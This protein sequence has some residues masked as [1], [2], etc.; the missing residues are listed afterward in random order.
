MSFQTRAMAQAPDLSASMAS[1]D[2]M[3]RALRANT[4]AIRAEW[5]EDELRTD[6]FGF[7]V[8]VDDQST[9]VATA[10]HVIRG[11]S[12]DT[13]AD[14][15]SVRFYGQRGARSAEIVAHYD[16]ALDVGV[17]KIQGRPPKPW[18]RPVSGPET[19]ARRGTQVWFV[20][21]S[22]T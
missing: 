4:V 19:A 9:Y 12:G 16:P 1:G 13:A 18:F 5:T 3:A 20:G 7:I 14:R 10:N 21:R 22:G 17:I 2:R 6:G 8:G 15:V 11:Y